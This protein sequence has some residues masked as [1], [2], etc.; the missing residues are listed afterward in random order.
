MPS[1]MIAISN[2]SCV[3][4]TQDLLNALLN[5]LKRLPV[6]AGC[7]CASVFLIVFVGVGAPVSSTNPLEESCTDL[8]S[9]YGQR[10][11]GVVDVDLFDLPQ[12]RSGVLGAT[13]R[14]RKNAEHVFA[15]PCPVH[16][17][18]IDVRRSLAGAESDE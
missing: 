7:Q 15:H 6:S 16:A 8:V 14:C 10:V 18:A 1:G 3:L 11:I 5:R 13:W 17:H 9:L 4:A 2:A 12:I